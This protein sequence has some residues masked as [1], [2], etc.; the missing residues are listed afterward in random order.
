MSGTAVEHDATE[1]DLVVVG[2]GI[3]GLA[4]AWEAAQ[5]GASVAVVERADRFGGRIRTSTLALTDGELPIDEGADAFLARVPGA[6]ELCRE[7]GLDAEFVTPATGRARVWVGGE[8]RPLPEQH[9][10]GV[11]VDADDLADTGL[12]SADSVAAVR[13]EG[14][15]TGAGPD[16]D[17]S[18]GAYLTDHFDRELVDHLVGPL[19]GGIN[20]GDV[21]RLSLEAVTPQLADAA[22]AG[23]SLVR[24]L[25]ER[26][27]TVTESGPVFHGL[28]GGT[29]T[30]I[31]ALVDALRGHGALLLGGTTVTDVYA[32]TDPG[33][34]PMVVVTSGPTL[35]ANGVVL[36]VP[37]DGAAT[38][39]APS[40]AAA[41]DLSA[42]EY[43]SVT[44]VTFVFRREDV[45]GP[46]DGSG[47]LVPRDAGMFLTAA[48]WG[49]S[50]WA[51]WDDGRHVILRVSAGHTGDQRVEHLDDAEVAR[52][53]LADLRTTMGIVAPPVTTRVSPWPRGFPQYQV[54]HLERVA[55]IEH[56]LRRDLPHVRVTGSAYRGL[57]IPACI[58]QGRRAARELLDAPSG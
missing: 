32:A 12:L 55:R 5:S 16:G 11:P 23:G 37:A 9:V 29:G 58:T 56:A 36:A 25:R 38:L 6:V 14:D 22:H 42:I 49:S 33:N 31:D 51:H 53:L 54:G 15:R 2:G 39:L 45:P 44:L 17:V 21:D 52:L 43:T 20:A 48:S 57:G 30:L 46:L 34:A 19:I 28:R 26:R 10:L 4:A 3:S 7:L 18:I 40:S 24:T 35:R 13:R 8:L 50:K 1:V 47:F 27:S 41:E